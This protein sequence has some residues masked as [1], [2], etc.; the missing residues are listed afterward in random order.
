MTAPSPAGAQ[1]RPYAA[2]AADP[3]T[4]DAGEAA[5]ALAG[6]GWRR[7]AA[8]GDSLAQGKGDPSPGYRDAC[9]AMRVAEALRAVQP[10]LSYL[11]TG[12]VGAVTSEVIER[13][14]QTALDFRPDLCAVVSGG[15]DLLTPGFSAEALHDQLTALFRPLR[16]AGADV[17]T[18]ALQDITAAYPQ[19]APLGL[20]TGLATLNEVIR[21]AAAEHGVSVIEMW[22]HP[23]QS[24]RDVYSADLMHASRRGHAIIAGVTV[25]HLATLIRPDPRGSQS[26]PGGATPRTPGGV[27][28]EEPAV[29]AT[30]MNASTRQEVG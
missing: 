27:P 20:R 24:A 21:Q 26:P 4:M 18:Y 13:Q 5:R 7:F 14:L 22:G 17:F 12:Q 23:A 28:D 16:Q 3:Y 6:A 9:W 29:S 2:E 1:A 8:V 15:N 10:R 25:R 30:P 11:N 19:L